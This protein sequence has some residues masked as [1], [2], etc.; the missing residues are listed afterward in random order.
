MVIDVLAGV[1]VALALA[2]VLAWKW[3]FG[4]ARSAL[5]MAAFGLVSG[6]AMWV[7][8]T[9][10]DLSG[11]VAGSAAALIALALGA[12]AV[13]FRFYRD[14]DR[15]PPEREDVVVSPADGEVVYVRDS[16]A[17]VLPVSTKHGLPHTL[18]ELTK[19]P[20]AEDDAVVVGIALSFLDV[21]VN[22][23]PVSG[24]VTLARRFPGRFGSLRKPEMIFENE[25]A[26][27]LIDRG[28]VTIG[29]VQIASRLV[30]RIVT[31][32][33]E[34][35]QLVLGVRIGAIRFG[36]QVD[37]VLPRRQDLK[38]TVRPGDRVRAGESI[39]AVLPGPQ[40][41]RSATPAQADATAPAESAVRR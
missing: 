34:G 38:V 1:V 9:A 37:V 15:S 10:V 33:S 4:L 18:T 36:S 6:T 20:F 2:L 32:V 14:P 40:Q 31:Y 30:R 25:R 16:S 39:V 23:A 3:Q 22:R 29:V 41:S 26:T 24:R 7:I 35:Q 11:I 8:A 13:L 27:L 21:H 17:G 19:T 5:W 28:D 12:A